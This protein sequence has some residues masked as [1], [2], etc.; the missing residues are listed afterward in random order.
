M[1]DRSYH[2]WKAREARLA[3]RNQLKKKV[4][5]K[6]S[7]SRHLVNGYEQQV[8]HAGCGFR[9]CLEALLAGRA[10]VAS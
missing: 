5:F 1:N 10:R 8:Y 4:D 9:A 7:Y 6:V 2:I 3:V